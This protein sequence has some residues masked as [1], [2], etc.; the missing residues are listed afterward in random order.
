MREPQA[1]RIRAHFEGTI[2][3]QQRA[4]RDCEGD[5]LE[6][7]RV[8]TAAFERGNKLL[9]CGNGGSAADCQHIAA[10]LVNVLDKA[11]PRPPL[12]AVAL[13][14]D[15]SFL[16]AAA[17]DFGFEGV[18]ERQV[19]ALGKAGDVLLAIT[20]SGRSANV[21]KAAR[22]AAELDMSVIGLAGS[23]GGAL[24]EVSDPCIVV[25]ADNTQHIQE[26]HIV[27]GHVL[28]DLVQQALFDC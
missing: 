12:A 21:L 9:L 23:D 11:F 22:R 27:I 14:T 26:T 24:P 17:N 2:E 28:C 18:F 19:E 13:T 1:E 4:L 20:T 16:T 3:A 8:V 10:E 25:P 15:T 7:A 5:I 6:A